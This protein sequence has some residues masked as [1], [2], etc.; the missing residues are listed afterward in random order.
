MSEEYTN[1]RGKHDSDPPAKMHHVE[2]LERTVDDHAERFDRLEEKLD[3][4]HEAVVALSATFAVWRAIAYFAATT[5]VGLF[6]WALSLVGPKG[7][8]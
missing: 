4:T 8:H 1:G 3:K 7:G 5:A 2:E 6:M